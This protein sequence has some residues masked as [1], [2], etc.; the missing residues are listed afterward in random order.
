MKKILLAIMFFILVML[1]ACDG[2]NQLFDKAETLDEDV[3]VLELYEELYSGNGFIIYILKD[4]PSIQHTIGISYEELDNDVCYLSITTTNAYIVL[5]D[6]DY[7]DLGNAFKLKLFDTVDLIDYGVLYQCHPRYPDTSE[8]VKC[9]L[10]DIHDKPEYSVWIKEDG[11]HTNSFLEDPPIHVMNGYSIYRMYLI[12]GMT[13]GDLFIEGY[14]FGHISA[15]CSF[16]L[17]ALGYYAVKDNVRY[18]IQDLVDEEEL[19]I[20]DIYNM[21]ICDQDRLGRYDETYIGINEI[22]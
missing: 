18:D 3:L 14:Y 12:C 8:T 20:K 10:Y 19:N 22:K 16:D 2:D 1:S 7:Y 13:V 6:E 21:Y 15:G 4:I 5:Y 11:T 17:D 9:N